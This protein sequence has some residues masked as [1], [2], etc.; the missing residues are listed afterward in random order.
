MI[1]VNDTFVRV[2]G[3]GKELCSEL[4]MVF[5]IIFEEYGIEETKHI[6]NLA[7]ELVIEENQKE[8]RQEQIKNKKEL[9]EKMKKNLPKDLAEM[10]CSLI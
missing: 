7:L 10:L 1:Y 3:K 2:K 4:A 9:K 8:Y 5:N 6:I